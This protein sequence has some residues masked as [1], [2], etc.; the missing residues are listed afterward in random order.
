MIRNACRTVG[1]LFVLG[2]TA[3]AQAGR[4][5]APP[6]G[7]GE[8]RGTVIDGKDTVPL[9]RASIAVRRK[10][11]SSLVAGAITGVN[12]AFRIQ[13]LRSGAY[14]L[15]ATA[16]GYTPKTLDI[17]VTHSAPFVSVG[18]VP[19]LPFPTALTSASIPPTPPPA[20][21]CP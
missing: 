16:I 7:N 5:A 21:T 14:T 9:N 19:L 20:P 15:R 18:A 10:R 1:F 3:Y 11:D 4:P 17:A 6:A 8:A 2:N 12:G 13:G